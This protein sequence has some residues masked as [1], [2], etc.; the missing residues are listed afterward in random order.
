MSTIPS[1]YSR[2][3][4]IHWK[5]QMFHSNL[6]PFR[7]LQKGYVVLGLNNSSYKIITTPSLSAILQ[8]KFQSG[9]CDADLT[10]VSLIVVSCSF[11]CTFLCSEPVRRDSGSVRRTRD[12]H[13]GI[14]QGSIPAHRT[15][16]RVTDTRAMVR[17]LHGSP[18]PM[19]GL[20]ATHLPR[21]HPPRTT[22]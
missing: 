16:R 11:V 18:S 15:G 5:S 21:L 8:V 4:Q 17:L 14:D 10:T 1:R 20:G 19:S 9:R 3:R 12:C 7:L 22:Y 2:W 6:P 13:Q